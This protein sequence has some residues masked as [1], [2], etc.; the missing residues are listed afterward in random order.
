VPAVAKNFR[1]IGPRVTDWLNNVYDFSQQL[2]QGGDARWQNMQSLTQA[3]VKDAGI[4]L[5]Q[6]MSNINS[7][8]NVMVE[9]LQDLR[10]EVVGAVQDQLATAQNAVQSNP[11]L[12]IALGVAAIFIVPELIGDDGDDDGEP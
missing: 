9:T 7:N 12:M 2:A 10:S 3:N 1:E 4:S 6:F 11:W 8:M 5:E